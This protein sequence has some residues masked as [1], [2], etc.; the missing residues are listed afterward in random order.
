MPTKKLSEICTLHLRDFAFTSVPSVL[1]CALLYESFSLSF[2][3]LEDPK[4]KGERR[5]HLPA[6]SP[7]EIKFNGLFD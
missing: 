4:E 6:P 7:I 3:I 2:Q 5:E 1:L